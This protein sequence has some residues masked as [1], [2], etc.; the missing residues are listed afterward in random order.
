[1]CNRIPLITNTKRKGFTTIVTY[2]QTD[3]ILAGSVRRR[4]NNHPGICKYNL[5]GDL[6]VHD[7]TMRQPQHKHH[8]N[9]NNIN[10]QHKY[11]NHHHHFNKN[12]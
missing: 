7:A 3:G 6:M 10:Q 2:T 4:S 9:N 8:I 1:M 5:D 12:T 11:N